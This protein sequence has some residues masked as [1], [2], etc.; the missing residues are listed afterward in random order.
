[1]CRLAHLRTPKPS[2]PNVGRSVVPPVKQRPTHGLG[3]RCQNLLHTA[4]YG[5]MCV[6]QLKNAKV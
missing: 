2:I 5:R 3:S 1:M 4:A 6:D